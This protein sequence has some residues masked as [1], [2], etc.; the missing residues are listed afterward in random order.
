[1]FQISSC[2]HLWWL[3]SGWLS[4]AHQATLSFPLLNRTE[5]EK[6][7]RTHESRTE[8]YHPVTVADK[9]NLAWENNLS[10]NKSRIMR[11]LKSFYPQ[12]HSLRQL[13]LLIQLNAS[14]PKKMA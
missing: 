7:T 6:V 1:M 10:V 8:R 11:S 4:G 9:T 14:F 13:A 5:R 3:D 12:T 2:K